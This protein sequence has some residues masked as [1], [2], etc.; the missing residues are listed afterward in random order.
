[1]LRFNDPVHTLV[2]GLY[3]RWHSI[4][5]YRAAGMLLGAWI[6]SILRAFECIDILLEVMSALA[7]YDKLA[8]AVLP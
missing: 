7:R 5:M 3:R 1:M 8:L 2:V 4:S 6:H